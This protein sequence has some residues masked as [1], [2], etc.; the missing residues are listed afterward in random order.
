M[1]TYDISQAARF[2]KLLAEREALL[3]T[4][5]DRAGEAHEA[6]PRE[7]VDFKDVAAEQALVTVD[8]AKTK[9]AAHDLE[10]VLV[11]RRRLDDRSYGYCMDCGEAIDL[12]RLTA[13]PA[14]PLCISCQAV[15]E[16]ERP[17]AMRR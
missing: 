10:E 5:G 9:H 17:T 12:R 13:M 4:T 3:R 11:G 2:S 7:V 8:E 6:E 16:H 14:A 1:E 15:N